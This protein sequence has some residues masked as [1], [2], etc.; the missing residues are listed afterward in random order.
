MPL[1]VVSRDYALRLASEKNLDLV[2]ISS[3]SIPSVCKI[4]DYG[5]FLFEKGKKEKGAKKN[6]RKSE[7]K[8]IR[9]SPNIAAHDFET[10][11]VWAQ[12]FAEKENRIK[13]TMKFKGREMAHQEIGLRVMKKFAK[14]CSKFSFVEKSPMIDGKIITM[15][16]SPNKKLD[17]KEKPV[18]LK[19]EITS[20]LFAEN[21]DN[22]KIENIKEE[23]S[24]AEIKNT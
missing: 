11:V 18:A 15:Y 9:L 23:N 24:D 5:K 2:K 3:V 19:S 6:R 7:L 14:A 10:R 1:G 8:E 20:G 16:I 4:T 22:I 17:V 12:G 13:I 21:S